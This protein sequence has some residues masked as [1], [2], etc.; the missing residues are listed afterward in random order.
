M[1]GEKKPH[2]CEMA[3]RK[4]MFAEMKRASRNAKYICP[5]C[6]RVAADKARLCCPGEDLYGEKSAG[7]SCRAGHK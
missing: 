3:G 1:T 5:G 6:G 2:M 7:K 4:E